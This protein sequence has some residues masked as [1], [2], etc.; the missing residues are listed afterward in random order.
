MASAVL[1]PY[2]TSSK[3]QGTR[4]RGTR[5]QIV[6]TS[7]GL[8][9]LDGRV[10]TRGFWSF[11]KQRISPLLLGSG[12]SF[13][14]LD[15]IYKKKTLADSRF[16]F[17]MTLDELKPLVLES[18]R[19]SVAHARSLSPSLKVPPFETALDWMEMKA[20][21]DRDLERSVQALREERLKRKRELERELEEVIP[22]DL[23]EC[24][25]ALKRLKKE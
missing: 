18:F 17:Y 7:L 19:E 10:D 25:R 9:T 3:Y 2:P 23:D 24:E 4:I 14:C 12:R 22:Q 20:Q 8:A 13:N 15:P 11:V 6:Q 21:L 1:F 16:L 5:G